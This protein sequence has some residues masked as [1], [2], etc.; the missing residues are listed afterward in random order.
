M[1]DRDRDKDRVTPQ[2]E[3]YVHEYEHEHEHEYEYKP[4]E[5]VVRY[6]TCARPECRYRT[7]SAEEAR[8]HELS[9]KGHYCEEEHVIKSR[10]R[11]PK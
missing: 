11:I 1:G 8:K 7:E 5:Y 2:H 4:R 3:G 10:I 6:Y 9:R